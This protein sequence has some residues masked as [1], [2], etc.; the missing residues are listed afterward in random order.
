MNYKL[1]GVCQFQYDL[2][3]EHLRLWP[4]NKKQMIF[5]KGSEVQSEFSQASQMQSIYL[6]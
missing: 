2:T 5:E 3:D 6:L 4:R 1:F